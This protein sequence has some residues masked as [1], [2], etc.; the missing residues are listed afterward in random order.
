[1]Y[2]ALKKGEQHYAFLD[3][4][5]KVGSLVE[6][7]P[8]NTSGNESNFA[9]QMKQN[10]QISKLIPQLIGKRSSSDMCDE[11]QQYKFEHGGH[12]FKFSRQK[13]GFGNPFF[14]IGGQ[15][16]R[17]DSSASSE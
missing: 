9:M 10:D 12:P 4:V 16:N 3:H 6:A 5:N 1:M 8:F 17:Q 15:D 11:G 7:A 13:V 14:N 2:M